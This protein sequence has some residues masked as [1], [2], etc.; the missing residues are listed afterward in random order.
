MWSQVTSLP[1]FLRDE[2]IEWN[3]RLG[4]G[5]FEL[6]NFYLSLLFFG[7]KCLVFMFTSKSK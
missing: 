3:V 6:V 1:D 7:F 2:R 4:S 5:Q